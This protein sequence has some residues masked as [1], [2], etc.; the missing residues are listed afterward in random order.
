MCRPN[1]NGVEN[2]I[3]YHIKKHFMSTIERK[4]IPKTIHFC[5]FGG[6]KKPALVQE[7]IKS[8]EKHLPDFTIKEWNESNYDVSAHPFTKR[9]HESKRWAFVSDYAR[10]EILSRHGGIYLDTDMDIVRDISPLLNC[11]LLLGKEGDHVISAGMIG[12]VP[13]HPY[14]QKCLK[15]YDLITGTPPTI[16]RLITEIYEE[17]KLDLQYVTVCPPIAFYPYSQETISNYRKEN[18]SSDTYGVHLWNYSWGNPVLRFANSLPLYHSL[19]RVLD[20]FGIKTAI[21]KILRLS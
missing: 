16:P 3:L 17:M 8:W 6:N 13:N 14:I 18:L 1:D 9:M 11:E 12:A 7:C 15:R 5:W 21:K 20:R 10:L 4:T 2:G 19:K